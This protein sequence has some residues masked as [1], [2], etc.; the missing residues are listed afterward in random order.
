MKK[1]IVGKVYTAHCL[2][3][4]VRI[5]G[6]GFYHFR[7]LAKERQRNPFEPIYLGLKLGVDYRSDISDSQC[8][9]FN[10][11]GVSTDKDSGIDFH[12]KR[13]INKD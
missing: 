10:S 7:I 1:I 4:G 2:D 13:R 8:Y 9:W 3:D 12:L 5:T 6:F 11:E